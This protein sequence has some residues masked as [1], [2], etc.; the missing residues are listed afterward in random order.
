MSTTASGVTSPLR[1]AGST[2]AR[3]AISSVKHTAT[4]GCYTS[5]DTFTF[6]LAGPAPVLDLR[7]FDLVV[8]NVAQKMDEGSAESVENSTVDPSP[9]ARKGDA[10]L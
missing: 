7:P 9:F 5:G 6:W 3:A 8:N 10:S 2:D 1:S 4:V